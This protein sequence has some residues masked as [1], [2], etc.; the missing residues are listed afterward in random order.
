MPALHKR[1]QMMLPQ[2]KLL[3]VSPPE[4]FLIT[5]LV[6]K[7]KLSY[8]LSELIFNYL[9]RPHHFIILNKIFSGH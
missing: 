4:V 8:L 2:I 9:N 7:L 1:A 6:F 5:G 3:T